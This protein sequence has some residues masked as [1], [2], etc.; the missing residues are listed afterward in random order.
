MRAIDRLD[1]LFET[2]KQRDFDRDFLRGWERYDTWDEVEV[3]R[4]YA[5]PNEYL[6]TAEDLVYYNR[7]VGEADP[8]T[9]DEAYAAERSP[10]G[11]VIA[12]PCFLVSMLFYCLGSAGAG[13]WLRT[14]GARNPFQDIELHE[15][16]YV[17][18][19]IRLTLTT[20]D[21][22]VRRGNHYITNLN[23]FRGGAG[24]LKVRAFGTLI[25]PPTR[26]EVRRFV[27]A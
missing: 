17:G 8:L 25:L 6:V 14:P 11:N 7:A 21:R 23:E 2:A 5:A 13:T 15:P 18:E 19:R 16:V 20:V 9:V 4:E 22:F 1:P 24:A 26:D 3:G 10:T 12:H 27:E